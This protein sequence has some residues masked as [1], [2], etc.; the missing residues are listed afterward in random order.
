MPSVRFPLS[1]SHFRLAARVTPG[2]SRMFTAGSVTFY[3]TLLVAG[4]LALA[5]APFDAAVAQE[6]ATKMFSATSHNFGTV[7]KGSKTEFRFVFRNIYKEDLHVVG[8]RTSCGCTSPEVTVR[9]LKTH[10]TG[11]VI[12]KFNTRTFLGQHGATLTVTFD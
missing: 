1:F 4:T 11:E 7:A 6:W 2:I 9:D 5:V 3:K 10:E 8:V 12:A